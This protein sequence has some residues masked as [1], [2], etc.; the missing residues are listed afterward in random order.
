[1]LVGGRVSAKKYDLGADIKALKKAIETYKRQEVKPEPEPVSEPEPEPVLETVEDIDLFFG[2]VSDMKNPEV[3]MLVEEYFFKVDKAIVEKNIREL[4]EIGLFPP[5]EGQSGGAKMVPLSKNAMKLIKKVKNPSQIIRDILE[6]TTYE[7]LPEHVKQVDPTS[8]V[9]ASI[10]FQAIFSRIFDVRARGFWDQGE[11]SEQC[12][13]TIGTSEEQAKCY[14]CDKE[15]YEE[16]EQRLPTCD[17]VL[18][19]AQGVFFLRLWQ[20]GYDVDEAMK[21]EYKWAHRC[22]NSIKSGNSFLQTF[23]DENGRP[24]FMFNRANVETMLQ[25]ITDRERSCTPGIIVEAGRADVIKA[26]IVDPILNYIH[27]EGRDYHAVLL[28]GFKNCV[29]SQNTTKLM[30]QLLDRYKSIM[31]R[32]ERPKKTP[33]KKPKDFAPDPSSAR[34]NPK[35]VERRKLLSEML[36]TTPIKIERTGLKLKFKGKPQEPAPAPEPEPEMGGRRRTLKKRTKRSK[37]SKRNTNAL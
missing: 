21:L 10:M 23:V 15:F 35:S 9:F 3:Q 30:R 1:M 28:A 2:L 14:I 7:E 33:A 5:M 20:D 24:Q 19:V 13:E 12:N 4:I 6:A 25:D 18:P 34:L 37:T 31:N 22:C 11:A 32:L 17:H 8:R 36:G 29:S 16:L 27:R 26:E